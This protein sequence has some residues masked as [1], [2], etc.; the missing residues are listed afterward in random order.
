MTDDGRKRLV[1]VAGS[2]AV[3]AFFAWLAFLLG[4]WGFDTRRYTQHDLR[5]QGMLKKKPR[6]E[7]V[8]RGLEDAV[9]PQVGAPKDEAELA[10]LIPE[11]AG[12]RG[13]AVRD[14]ARRW[15]QVRV[16]RA[17]DMLYFVFFD[18]EGN[19]RD[20]ALVSA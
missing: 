2:V 5:L 17:E 15:P 12:P 19:M 7:Q 10:R 4:A 9:I 13:Q 3:T 6:L 1:I 14:K 11:R 18:A 20:Y 8:V 16:F